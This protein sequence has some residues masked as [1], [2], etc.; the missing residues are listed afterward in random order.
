MGAGADVMTTNAPPW[1]QLQDL[2]VDA[3]RIQ[4]RWAKAMVTTARAAARGEGPDAGRLMRAISTEYEGYLRDLGKLNV[5]YAKSLQD[6]AASAGERLAEVVEDA[7]QR[8]RTHRPPS[9]TSTRASLPLEGTLGARASGTFTVAN[10]RAEPAQLSFLAGSLV[11]VA[12]PDADGLEPWFTF[13]PGIV[14]LEP[15]AEATVAVSL[16]LDPDRF[17]PGHEYRGE[18][19]VLGGDGTR[20]DVTVRALPDAVAA[21]ATA[22]RRTAKATKPPAKS[23]S[24]Q[25]T[26]KKAAAARRPARGR[27]TPPAPG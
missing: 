1:Q 22:A 25:K 4:S 13:E 9:S 20:L 12:A 23:A 6:L 26:T 24:A 15:G 18:V 16:D 8:H 21:T 5:Q 17:R 11:D 3:A 2:V 14:R 27:R 10:S 7:T 19:Q